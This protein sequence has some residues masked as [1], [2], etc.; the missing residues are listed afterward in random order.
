MTGNQNKVDD[1]FNIKKFFWC[2][3]IKNYTINDDM[4]IDVDGDVT[5]YNNNQDTLPLKFNNVSGDFILISTRLI[6][7]KGCPN[8]IGGEWSAHVKYHIFP[9]YKRYLL[10]K[11]IKEYC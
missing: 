6:S 2:N 4:S 8:Y 10:T 7:L 3:S 9:E 5:I 11:K 1:W